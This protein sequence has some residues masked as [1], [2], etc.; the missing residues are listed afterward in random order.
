MTFQNGTFI[1]IMTVFYFIS[2][3]STSNTT[4]GNII[5]VAEH[6]YIW[7]AHTLSGLAS[8]L[9]N[10]VNSLRQNGMWMSLS[11]NLFIKMPLKNVLGQNHL[12]ARIAAV[13]HHFW[14]GCGRLIHWILFIWR[15][16]IWIVHYI[17]CPLSPKP[18]LWF[19][20]HS[21]NAVGLLW[22]SSRAYCSESVSEKVKALQYWR[23]KLGNTLFTPEQGGQT[24]SKQ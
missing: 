21:P 5:I 3:C 11:L 8:L 9:T 6:K 13:S 7:H 10:I 22:L 23:K 12:L 19:H 4:L 2:H 15:F 17:L 20:Y 24:Q 14:G 18:L 1:F 16:K